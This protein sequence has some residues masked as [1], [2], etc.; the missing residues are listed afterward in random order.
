MN[1]GFRK[2]RALRSI[3][4]RRTVFDEI[5]G[6]ERGCVNEVVLR[7]CEARHR[8]VAQR[9]AAMKHRLLVVVV[10]LT[11]S[12]FEMDRVGPTWHRS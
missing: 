8:W 3:C 6:G 1:R 10:S 7:I 5:I 12:G 11:E 4:N 2:W 9:K